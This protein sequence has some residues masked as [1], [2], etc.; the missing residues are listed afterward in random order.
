[1][2]IYNDEHVLGASETI[3]DSPLLVVAD[4]A[5][6][7]NAPARFLRNGIGD[8]IAKKFEAERAF[9]DGAMNFFGTRPLRTALAIAAACYATLRECGV[10]AMAAAEAHVPDDAFEAVVEGHVLMAGIAWENCRLRPAERRV[11]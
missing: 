1:M 10:A 6:I 4:T 8:A 7:A 5:L 2:A 9:A 11:G 3:P